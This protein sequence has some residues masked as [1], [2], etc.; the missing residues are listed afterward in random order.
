LTIF[1]L[2]DYIADKNCKKKFFII[3]GPDVITREIGP[4]SS[5]TSGKGKSYLHQEHCEQDAQ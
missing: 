2:Q 5:S 3:I 4:K 1:N